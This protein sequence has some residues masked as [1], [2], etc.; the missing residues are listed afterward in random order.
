M[1]H[2]DKLISL[3][4]ELREKHLRQL[5]KNKRYHEKLE[6]DKVLLWAHVDQLLAAEHGRETQVH[7]R[8]HAT[9]RASNDQAVAQYRLTLRA[10]RAN[11]ISPA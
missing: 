11:V 2:D 6:E 4:A 8:V 5:L 7:H 1:T 9:E 3:A 10:A